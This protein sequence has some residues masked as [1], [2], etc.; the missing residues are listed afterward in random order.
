MNDSP[1]RDS[2]SLDSM[3]A[4][5]I[6]TGNFNSPILHG[7]PHEFLAPVS[8]AGKVYVK[9]V[10]SISST[11][12]DGVRGNFNLEMG[13]DTLQDMLDSKKNSALEAEKLSNCSTHEN[14][15]HLKLDFHNSFDPEAKDDCG[16]VSSPQTSQI[17]HT[18]SES[19]SR[20]E[21]VD[22]N[23]ADE[24]INE[25]N[26]SSPASD[27]AEN[28]LF[29]SSLN[30]YGLNH[31]V[32]DSDMD[33]TNME[34]VL[35]PD[36]VIYRDNYCMGLK[37]TFSQ[38]CIQINDST[39]C[40]KEG[41]INI[42]WAVEDLIDIKSQSFQSTGMVLMT[43]RLVSSDTVQS[44][45]VSCTSGIDEL[46]IAIVDHN[47]SFRHK[48]I[49]SLN[50][51]YLAMWSTLLD[52]DVEGD[53]N[54]SPA[55]RCYFPNFQQPFDEVVYPKGDPDAVSLSKRDVDLLQPDTFVNDTVIDFYIQ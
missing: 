17:D 5:Q 52:M 1:R 18:P 31:C 8:Q 28:G 51:K 40:E 12:V 29:Y 20:T 24:C 27:I 16:G 23:E 41:T 36:Y 42:E 55:P 38:Y 39:A 54:L 32:A 26:P 6:A 3:D 11:D 45:N 22:T 4:D 30:G 48:Q 25:S 47:W 34:V 53:E 9:D 35:H 10:A 50:E 13:L 33:D 21:S 14:Q 7:Q 43:L 46:K 49:T 44:N 37:L 15:R 2:E 19:P